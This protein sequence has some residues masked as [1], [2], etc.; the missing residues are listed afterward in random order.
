MV[1]LGFLALAVALRVQAYRQIRD[2][3][4]RLTLHHLRATAHLASAMLDGDAVAALHAEYPRRDGIGSNYQDP[5]Y[6]AVHARLAEIARGAQLTSPIYLFVPTAD[7]GE[8]ELTATSAGEPYWRHRYKVSP[9]LAELPFGTPGELGT[10]R[11]HFGRW[12]SAFAPV[13]DSRGEVVAM[14]QADEQFDVFS[15]KASAAALKGLWWNALLFV[16]VGAILMRFLGQTMRKE[17][18]LRGD[19]EGAVRKQTEFSD[20][21]AAKQLELAQKSQALEQSNRDLTD[22]ANIASHDLK[23]PL[24]GIVNF[25]QLLARRNRATLDPASNEYLDFI[26]SSGKRAVALVDGLLDYAKSDGAQTQAHACELNDVVAQSVQALQAVISER[27]AEVHVGPLSRATCDPVLISQLFQ[28]MIGNGLKYNRSEVPEVWVAEEI[29][30]E[31]QTVFSVRDNGI[32]IPAESRAVV[33]EMFRR[34]H[35]GEEFE[36]SGI[37]LAFCTRLVARYGGTVWLASEEGLGSTFHF[38]LPGAVG[39]RAA[40]TNAV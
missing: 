18:R 16:A 33:F 30:G 5:R 39:V 22:F 7:R 25:S 23:S 1:G 12:L 35:G 17:Q 27:G 20:A 38:T 36:G 3:A 19:A 31:G 2:Q 10:Y 29:D 37:G 40:V 21:L 4:E 32:G 14:V 28:N 9:Q 15:A 8:M 24:R 13:Y 26:I 11:D 34:L 6:T